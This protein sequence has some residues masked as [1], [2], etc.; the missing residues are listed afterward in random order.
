LSSVVGDKLG[1][2]PGSVQ[3]F[4]SVDPTAAIGIAALGASVKLTGVACAEKQNARKLA[5]LA[6]P[7]EKSGSESLPAD[8]GPAVGGR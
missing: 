1:R 3:L 2:Q 5:D 6:V 4:T 7:D 8:L